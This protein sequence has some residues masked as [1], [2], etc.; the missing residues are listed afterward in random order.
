MYIDKLCE[1]V[2]Q[3]HELQ[4]EDLDKLS[5]KLRKRFY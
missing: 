4:K 1:H 2:E 5:E 3:G